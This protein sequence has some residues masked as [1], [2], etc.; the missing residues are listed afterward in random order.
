M[1]HTVSR[2]PLTAEPGF[3]PHASQFGIYGGQIGIKICFLRIGLFQ[4]SPV[5]VI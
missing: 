2:R 3:N 5:S 1:P 4:F